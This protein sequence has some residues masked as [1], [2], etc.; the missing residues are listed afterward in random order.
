MIFSVLRLKLHGCY[1][2][3]YA[4]VIFD[5]ALIIQN[6]SICDELSGYQIKY[7]GNE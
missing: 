3:A 4:S 2:V 1:F 5:W 6:P 7:V